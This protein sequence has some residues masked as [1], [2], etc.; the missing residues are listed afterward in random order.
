MKF[1]NVS[2]NINHII[3][4]TSKFFSDISN[5]KNNEYGTWSQ[6]SRMDLDN[7]LDVNGNQRIA[8]RLD[9]IF[10]SFKAN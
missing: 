5:N 9:K 8:N 1:Q 7:F 2:N 3:D 6:K 4:Q 10:N